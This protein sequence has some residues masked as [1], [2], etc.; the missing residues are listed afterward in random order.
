MILEANLTKEVELQDIKILDYLSDEEHALIEKHAHTRYYKKRSIIFREGSINSGIYIVKKGVVKTYKVGPYGRYHIIGLVKPGDIMA[1]H[2][3]FSNRSVN[4][5]S[6]K[7]CEDS[8]VCYIP[9][10]IVTKLLE[11]NWSF[12]K[13][14]MEL[15][16]NELN[17]SN[18]FVAGFVQK[19]LRE[20]TAELLLALKEEFGVDETGGLRLSITRKDLACMVGTV[21][22]S[23]I[24]VL[25]DFKKERLLDLVS[26]KIVLLD[27]ARLRKQAC[28]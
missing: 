13:K 5:T 28:Y 20:R 6:A 17:A 9:N 8:V 25:S 21:P 27:I 16:S 10:S 1:Y 2:S 4:N 3:L 14:M 22:E 12:T 19:S 18:T 7:A 24:R 23:L 26:K 15:I 11:S